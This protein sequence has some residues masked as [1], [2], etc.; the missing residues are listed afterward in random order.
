MRARRSSSSASSVSA[1]AVSCARASAI[2]ETELWPPL[3]HMVFLMIMTLGG[4]AGS[5]SGT[6]NGFAN[7]LAAGRLLKLPPEKLAAHAAAARRFQ[8]AD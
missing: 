4:M 5:T 3:L 6:L 7:T 2:A 8:P 1:I